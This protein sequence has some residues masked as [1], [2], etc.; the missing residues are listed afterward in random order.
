MGV[1]VAHM[2]RRMAPPETVGAVAQR[3]HQ[4][5]SLKDHL[6]EVC[7]SLKKRRVKEERHEGICTS[8]L[9]TMANFFQDVGCQATDRQ[10]RLSIL[11]LFL[12]ETERDV[13]RV[14]GFCRTTPSK[15]GCDYISFSQHPC[16]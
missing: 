15:N 1:H 10:V 6:Q 12:S 8:G 2:P 7:C 3:F 4:I 11:S 13:R 9:A 16:S 14:L 5:K